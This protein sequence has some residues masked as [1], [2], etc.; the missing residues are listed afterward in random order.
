MDWQKIALILWFIFVQSLF[1]GEKLP[2]DV[3]VET[4]LKRGFSPKLVAI[5]KQKAQGTRED[6]FLWK[7]S[8]RGKEA[9][10]VTKLWKEEA[11]SYPPAKQRLGKAEGNRNQSMANRTSDPRSL[12][13]DPFFGRVL[14][15]GSIP[16]KFG[17]SVFA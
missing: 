6:F 15:C 11:L 9:A 16:S 10:L 5:W 1:A 17:C 2:K 4:L 3:S 7:R 8:L 14:V 13:P 12:S